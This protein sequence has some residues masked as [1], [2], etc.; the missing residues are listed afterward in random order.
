MFPDNRIQSITLRCDTNIFM[1]SPN[2]ARVCEAALDTCVPVNRTLISEFLY[3]WAGSYPPNWVSTVTVHY[4]GKSWF[5]LSNKYC[6][7][8]VTLVNTKSTTS[9]HRK[10][11]L[12][13]PLHIFQQFHIV[14]PSLNWFLSELMST[15]YNNLRDLDFSGTIA[16][17]STRRFLPRLHS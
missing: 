13:K 7:A 16:F 17:R 5:L 3:R 12:P 11:M 1:K 6:D 2:S 9:S 10:L 4:S 14:W 8:W 15:S